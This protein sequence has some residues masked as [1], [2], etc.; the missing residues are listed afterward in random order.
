MFREGHG[1]MSFAEYV[2]LS[3]LP[4]W[5]VEIVIQPWLYEM[6]PADIHISD[7]LEPCFLNPQLLLASLSK[8]I[9]RSVALQMS[10]LFVI[11]YLVDDHD[12]TVTKNWFSLPDGTLLNW[13]SGLAL[14]HGPEGDPSC[15]MIL[16]GMAQWKDRKLETQESCD[17]I[18]LYRAE[19]IQSLRMIT[20]EGGLS[21]RL[22]K[23]FDLFYQKKQ[24]DSIFHSLIYEVVHTPDQP[25]RFTFEMSDYLIGFDRRIKFLLQRVQLCQERYGDASLVSL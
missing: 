7:E 4:S 18:C 14:S 6:K 21:G 11:G 8:E 25:R 19:T 20:S 16:C 1:F 9:S 3:V 17:H 12:R 13:D 24:Q 23:T 10:D 2:L 15:S 22:K 5:D